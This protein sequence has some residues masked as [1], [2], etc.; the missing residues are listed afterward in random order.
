MR[1]NMWARTR[2]ASRWRMGRTSSS[3][4][5][6]RKKPLDVFESLVAQHHIVAFEGLFGQAGAQHVDAVEGGLGGDGLGVAGERERLVG[7]LDGGVFGHLVVVED[8]SPPQR[9]A[10]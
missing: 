7:E 10:V 2:S 3:V 9:G 8:L 4:L 5:R 1:K 6:V